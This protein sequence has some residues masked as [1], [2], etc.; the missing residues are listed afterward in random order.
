MMWLLLAVGGLS[1]GLLAGLL[2]IGGGTVLVPILVTLGYSYNQSVA[3]SSL[4]IVMTSISGTIQNWRMGYLNWRHVILLGLPAILTALL[5]AYL[6]TQLSDYFKEAAF[7]ILLLINILLLSWRKRLSSQKNNSQKSQI[8]PI[9]ARS[10]TGATAGLLAGLFGIGGGAIMVPLQMLLLGEK[11][12]TAIQTSLGAIVI[13]SI[14]ACL[15][16][17]QSGN[18][19]WLE[20]LVLG[21]GGLIGA[22]FSTRFLPKL[23]DTIVSLMF[24]SLLAILALYFFWRASISYQ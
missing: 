18:V 2:G 22:Q 6:V 13:S 1:S 10:A 14:A 15:G 3:T 17:A 12:K 19:L 8:N 16:H 5:G 21:T 20:G 24:R 9:L 11:I 23:P 4:A 7:G